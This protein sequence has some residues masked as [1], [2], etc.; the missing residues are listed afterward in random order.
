MQ[1]RL[2]LTESFSNVTNNPSVS[3]YTVMSILKHM[4]KE[5]GLEAMSEFVDMYINVIEKSHPELRKLVQE[6]LSE[7]AINHFYQAAVDHEKD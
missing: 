3:V 2:D 7:Q 1:E 4:R 5:L 6:A